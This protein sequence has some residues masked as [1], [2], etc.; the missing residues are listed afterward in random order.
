MPDAGPDDRAMNVFNRL[1]HWL[2]GC[3]AGNALGSLLFVIFV[4]LFSLT[5]LYLLVTVFAAWGSSGGEIFRALALPAALGGAWVG[6]LVGM[7]IGALVGR[8]DSR[9]GQRWSF[10]G[11][12]TGAVVTAYVCLPNFL[13]PSTKIASKPVATRVLTFVILTA[14]G[15]LVGHVSGAIRRLVRRRT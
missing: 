2:R 14:L 6:G 3:L 11:W 7:T 4:A 15:S 9:A 10:P 5:P 8:A 12:L 13:D 1:P